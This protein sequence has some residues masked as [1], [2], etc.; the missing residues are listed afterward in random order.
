MNVLVS[1]IMPCHNGEVFLKPAIE[2]FLKNDREDFELLI[3]NDGST[4]SSSEIIA[5]FILNAPFKNI[6]SI[7]IQHSGVSA[8]RN[9][10]IQ[11]SKG[12]YLVFFDS[13]D[14]LSPFFISSL[15]EGFDIPDVDFSYC[16]STNSLKWRTKKQSRIILPET[17][18][19]NYLYHKQSIHLCSI[20]FL[21]S[22]IIA[23]HIA[24]DEKLSYGEDIDFVWKYLCFSKKIF[25]TKKCLFYHRT[26]LNS[27]MF[28]FSYKKIDSISVYERNQ[29]IIDNQMPTFSKRYKAYAIPRAVISIQKELS[30]HNDKKMF[31]SILNK[32]KHYCF[33][34]LLF[35]DTFKNRVCSL[36]YLI[37][38]SIFFRVIYRMYG[39]K[40]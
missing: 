37:S 8:A 29:T 38:P 10:G 20:M 2:S 35:H 34:S 36:I 22:E 30:I 27:V 40:K 15:L 9:I 21:K 17:F 6:K 11:N 4:D 7:C 25:F 5:Q 13:D 24:F 1:I 32:Y 12:K 14:L 19:K 18:A 33:F 3:I 26:N 28:K 31:V 39:G 23:N 16:C